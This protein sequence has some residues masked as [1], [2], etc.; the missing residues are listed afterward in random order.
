[1]TNKELRASLEHAYVRMEKAGWLKPAIRPADNNDQ[2]PL[3][4]KGAERQRELLRAF[5]ELESA[6]SGRLFAHDLATIYGILRS[7]APPELYVDM[8]AAE[9]A[10]RNPHGK[11]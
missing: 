11:N 4:A 10:A 2:L 5:L 6:D 9:E 8:N 1:M 3:T 7:Y